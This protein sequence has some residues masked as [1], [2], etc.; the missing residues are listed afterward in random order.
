MLMFALYAL[1][2][3]VQFGLFGLSASCLAVSL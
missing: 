3:E 2:T 1:E